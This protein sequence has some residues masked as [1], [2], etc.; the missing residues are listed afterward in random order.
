MPTLVEE[1]DITN[2]KSVFS[3]ANEGVDLD[4]TKVL[5]SVTTFYL[6]SHDFN[7]Y[8]V[9]KLNERIPTVGRCKQKHSIEELV[10][11]GEVDVTL[12]GNTHIK[13]FNI[14]DTIGQIV[15]LKALELRN[16]SRLIPKP[17]TL[18]KL[19]E[20]K[21]YEDRPYT[22][23]LALGEGQLEYRSFDLSVLEHYRNEPSIYL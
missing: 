21:K 13:P 11:L 10:S 1:S 5:D 20:L 2:H 22:K 7:G 15:G 19:P 3:I 14:P 8:P 18:A 9:Y 17:E 16:T 6:E 12:T 23:A 4:R